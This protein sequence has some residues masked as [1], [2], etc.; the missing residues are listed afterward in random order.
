MRSISRRISRKALGAGVVAAVG[1][2]ALGAGLA[3]AADS[4]SG[5]GPSDVRL[6]QSDPSTT[7]P[8]ENPDDGGGEDRGRGCDHE[9]REGGGPSDGAT[10][11]RGSPTRASQTS[12]PRGSASSARWG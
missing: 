1:A 2:V 7:V 3:G 12:F 5:G 8:G 10:A 9:K 11:D 4:G 6:V